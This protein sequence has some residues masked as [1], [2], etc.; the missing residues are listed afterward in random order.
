MPFEV[1]AWVLSV[2]VGWMSSERRVWLLS[3]EVDEVSPGGD[4]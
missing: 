4:P 2:E 1:G 3:V